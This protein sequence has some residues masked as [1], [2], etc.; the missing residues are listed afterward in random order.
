MASAAIETVKAI[1]VTLK[2][3]ATRLCAVT[4]LRMVREVTSTS[5]TADDVPTVKAK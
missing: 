3:K 2:M 4:V 5:E 1:I